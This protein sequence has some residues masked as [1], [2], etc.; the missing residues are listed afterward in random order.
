MNRAF[1][2]NRSRVRSVEVVRHDGQELG[3]PVHALITGANGFIGM[4]L[5]ERLM[6]DGRRVRLFVRKPE[7]VARLKQSGAEVVVGTLDDEEALARAVDGVETVY[8]LAAMTAA[9]RVD[10]MMRANGAGSSNI[11]RAC[12]AGQQRP[13][14]VHVSS[15]AAAGPTE[16]GRVRRE[17]DSPAPI[18]NYG[19]SKHAGE[20]AVAE[21]AAQVPITIVRPG[22]V[23]GPRNT[24]MLPMFKTIKFAHFH[25]VPG[26]NPPQ[27]SLMH[28]EDCVEVLLRA[29]ETGSRLSADERNVGDRLTSGHGVYFA[30]AP[31]FPDYA[32]LGRTLCKLLGRPC[33]PVVSLPGPLP[34][35]VA[36][37]NEKVLGRLRSK[38]DTFN[39]DKIRE[40][41]AESWACSGELAAR[42][43]GV[44]P[45]ASLEERLASTVQWYRQN[46]WL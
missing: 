9:L 39:L 32:E 1:Q 25:P 46:R 7:T 11:A 3:Q 43:L 14:L 27:L 16:R 37:I 40:A 45:I 41:R 35:I 18:S 10:D 28:V 36:G 26:R 13:V 12:A 17:T 42:E 38:P 5:T 6:A 2:E 30:T 8:H 15:I 4:H 24:E 22:I 29:A 19:R 44:K 23:F 33:A 20:L 31:E 34:W 21:H